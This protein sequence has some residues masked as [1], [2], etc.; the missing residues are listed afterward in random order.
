MQR[1]MGIANHARHTSIYFHRCDVSKIAS[2]PYTPGTVQSSL[3]V[4]PILSFPSLQGISPSNF[5]VFAAVS[6]LSP[7]QIPPRTKPNH[8]SPEYSHPATRCQDL[9]PLGS[10]SRLLHL[11]IVLGPAAYPFIRFLSSTSNHLPSFPPRLDPLSRRKKGDG[12]NFII[13]LQR[14]QHQTPRVDTR[15]VRVR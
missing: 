12:S 3:P 4:Q 1:S 13:V 15:H 8:A 2:R 6:N 5:Q 14:Q 10:S 11:S 7:Y 9:L